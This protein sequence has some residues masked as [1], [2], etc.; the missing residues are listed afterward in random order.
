MAAAKIKFKIVTPEKTVF[1]DE[2]DQVTLPVTDGQV[3]ILPNHTSYI[4]SL[5]AG[6]IIFKKDGEETEMATSGGFIEFDKNNLLFLADTAERVEE[7]DVEEA[8][9]AKARAEE[10]MKTRETLDDEEYAKVAAAIERESARI[11]VAKKH[12]TKKGIHIN[13]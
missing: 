6:E 4:A 13:Q 8:E 12:Y 2:V 7:I 11:R 1:E 10:L 3:T 5:K 9:K